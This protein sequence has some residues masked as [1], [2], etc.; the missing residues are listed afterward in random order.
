LLDRSLGLDA[1]SPLFLKV[2]DLRIFV[3]KRDMA[4]SFRR[5]KGVRLDYFELAVRLELTW[6]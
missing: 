4:V 3:Q 1:D 6:Q 2:Y 5:T